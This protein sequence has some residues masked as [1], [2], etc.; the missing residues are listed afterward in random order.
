[1]KKEE[2]NNSSNLV[3]KDE[4]VNFGDVKNEIQSKEKSD[5][6]PNIDTKSDSDL[7]RKQYGEIIVMR[8]T[9]HVLLGSILV[10]NTIAFWFIIFS[11]GFGLID[12][13]YDWVIISG[14]IA[15]YLGA[16][17]IAVKFIFSTDSL[18]RK[19]EDE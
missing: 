2:S 11:I 12:Y 16:I 15:E 18:Y 3:N 6:N 7:Q 8:W 10:L 13:D 1:M 19:H 4:K 17:K 14:L 9:W 5:L